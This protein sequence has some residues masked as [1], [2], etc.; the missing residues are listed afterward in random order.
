[1]I[2]SY[3]YLGALTDDDYHFPAADNLTINEVEHDHQDDQNHNY[4]A[5]EDYG[6]DGDKS[7]DLIDL[8]LTGDLRKDFDALTSSLAEHLQRTG[9]KN[10]DDID[11]RG[12]LETKGELP[13]I[14]KSL[15]PPTPH[16]TSSTTTKPKHVSGG[17]GIKF[18]RFLN[19]DSSASSRAE[20]GAGETRTAVTQSK[21]WRDQD[22]VVRAEAASDPSDSVTLCKL[23]KIC[24][25]PKKGSNNSNKRPKAYVGG[26][27]L[28]AMG[29][30]TH[31]SVV[32]PPIDFMRKLTR[33][34][35]R[36]RR[37]KKL[38][39]RTGEKTAGEVAKLLSELE[40]LGDV[41]KATEM[42]RG[43]SDFSEGAPLDEG[44]KIPTSGR[45]PAT[46]TPPS[47]S[48]PAAVEAHSPIENAEERTRK[49]SVRN[50]DEDDDEEDLQHLDA[51]VSKAEVFTVGEHNID[52][53]DSSWTPV[54]FQSPLLD[55]STSSSS[56]SL[57]EGED[58]WK[59][60]GEPLTKQRD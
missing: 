21:S 10:F 58:G 33:Q 5:Y 27:T 55:T 43:E 28:A 2:D 25:S 37:K 16:P 6:D 44:T 24:D 22:D 40:G 7:V 11:I 8:K 14:I 57:S 12:L 23:M 53:D 56:Q 48:E 31:R 39:L 60:I 19:F 18:D 26:D 35:R 54:L 50:E 15:T 3:Y 42:K 1:M 32:D 30:E 49:T 36:R 29:S 52:R 59:P 38:N 9:N 45:P 13:P 34:R 46:A 41:T 47:D 20:S 51:T 4:I 17:G